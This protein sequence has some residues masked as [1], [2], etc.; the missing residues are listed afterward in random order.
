MQSAERAT[1]LHG[2]IAA[3]KERQSRVD[4]AAAAIEATAGVDE[5]KQLALMRRKYVGRAAP[6]TAR[7]SSLEPH[8]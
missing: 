1:A 3:L 5:R 7:A 6:R 4:E 8:I 2:K